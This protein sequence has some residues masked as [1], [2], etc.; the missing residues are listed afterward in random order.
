MSAA[1]AA[2]GYLFATGKLSR[3]GASDERFEHRVC[4]HCHERFRAEDFEF[5]LF[6]AHKHEAK[7]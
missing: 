2:A 1:A 7:P 6:I 5:H 4:A 3:V